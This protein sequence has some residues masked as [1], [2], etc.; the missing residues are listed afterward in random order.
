MRNIKVLPLTEVYLK[1]TEKLDKISGNSVAELLDSYE[2][3]WGLFKN[4][5]L[6]GYCT[7]GYA[8]NCC[9]L[10]TSHKKYSYNSLLLSDVFIH[11]DYRG[12][13]HSLYL[14]NEAIKQANESCESV[15]LTLLDDN[16]SYL[17]K[18]CGFINISSNIMI[19]I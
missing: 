2:Y 13:N 3:A 19:K 10:I 18:K 7:L 1:E 17:Y 16:L 15:F 6:I 5:R 11:P 9:E 8:D 12:N 4:A 14:I